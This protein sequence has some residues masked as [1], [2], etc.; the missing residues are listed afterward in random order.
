MYFIHYKKNPKKTNK[1]VLG[2]TIVKSVIF[3]V[4]NFF[5]SNTSK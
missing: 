4:I 2:E 3:I 1:Y 5:Y